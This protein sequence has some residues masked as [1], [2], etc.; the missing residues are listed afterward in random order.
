MNILRYIPS[1]YE[2]AEKE[3]LRADVRELDLGIPYADMLR[4][5]ASGA[6]AAECTDIYYLACEDGALLSRL[7]CGWGK[8]ANAVGNFG[9]FVTRP[10][11]RGRGIGRAL[12]ADW[13]ASLDRPD[14]PLAF[15]CNAGAPHLVK[16]YEPYGFRLAVDGTEVGPLYCPLGDSPTSFREFCRDYYTSVSVTAAP[17][18]V[19]YRHEIDCLLRFAL[20]NEGEAL[21]LAEVGSMEEAY[22]RGMLPD[23]LLYFNERGRV[24]GWGMRGDEPQLHPACRFL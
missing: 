3:L 8:H 16:L 5:R 13:Q 17:A 20:M 1:E 9:N 24:V 4:V 21:G 23:M 22:L 6:L 11:L 14:R 19:G 12:L 18:S 15:F 7:W 2:I 10:D